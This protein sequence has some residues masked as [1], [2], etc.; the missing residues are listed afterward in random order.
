MDLHSHPG[1]IDP[2]EPRR[3]FE[4]KS[5]LPKHLSTLRCTRHPRSQDSTDHLTSY[6][7]PEIS[8]QRR[9]SRS[10][11]DGHRLTS[12]SLPE[13]LGRRR[14]P[15]AVPTARGFEDDVARDVPSFTIVRPIARPQV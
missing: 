12:Y 2:S 10:W 13:I 4:A 7:P 3:P 14:P 11:N 6:P 8:G 15:D 1:H 9:H 5:A